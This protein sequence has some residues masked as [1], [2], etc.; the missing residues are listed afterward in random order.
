[1]RSEFTFRL[2]LLLAASLPVFCF[3]QPFHD[4]E[5]HSPYPVASA[6]YGACSAANGD[7]IL[8]G[9]TYDEDSSDVLVERISGAGTWIW[10]TR[11]RGSQ[12]AGTDTAVSVYETPQG[13]LR[14]VATAYE[15]ASTSFAA[16][17]ELSASGQVL[18]SW[19]LGG[20]GSGMIAYHGIQTYD[21]NTVI[22]GFRR[23]LGGPSDPDGFLLKKRADGDTLWTRRFELRSGGL[24]SVLEIPGGGFY[25]AGYAYAP[26]RTNF[27]MWLI[28][29][30]TLGV[31]QWR[32]NY[33]SN[34]HDYC[35]DVSLTAGGDVYLAGSQRAGTTYAG[36]LHK[37]TASGTPIW[38]F[39]L[40]EP[41]E[42]RQFYGIAGRPAG[43][44]IAVG[45]TVLTGGSRKLWCV[46]RANSGASEG[47]WSWGESETSGLNGI[48]QT[49]Q[50]GWI[51]VG[52]KVENDLTRGYAMLL[53]APTG[54]RGQLVSR[55]THEPL[56]NVSVA[57]TA[58]ASATV[59]SIAGYYSL[60][61]DPGVYDI[62]TY[63]SCVETDTTFGITV[64]EDSSSVRNIEVG[65]PAYDRRLTSLNLVGQNDV[66]TTTQIYFRNTGTGELYFGIGVENSHPASNWIWPLPSYGVIYPGDSVA[67]VIHLAP[68]TTNNG[69]WEFSSTLVVHMNT[70]P[71][72]VDRIPVLVTVLD[73]DERALLPRELTMSA[74][75]PN[76]FNAATTIRYELGQ[77]A[78]VRLSIF[79]LTG[80]EVRALVAMVQEPGTHAVRFE[81][82]ELASGVYF[83]RLVA[84]DFSA[85]TKLLLLK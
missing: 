6:F 3:A 80:R 82:A 74:L 65:V 45:T 27:D 46:T 21:G 49:N 62:V 42:S 9:T 19:R 24:R 71:D 34:G 76:P 81:G 4:W 63:G 55:E 59:S 60:E 10:T 32:L 5:Y 12:W 83:V 43:G 28:R 30:D 73:A 44:C 53:P 64:P 1:M 85:A 38:N 56:R 58:G 69:A 8:V 35:F 67:V 79:D 29:T 68:D 47:D 84:G 33:G 7:Y 72:S 77:R 22:A 48:F 70:C 51:I 66:V 2:I 41:G 37:V 31:E 52:A 16:V 57:T 40:A 54:V 39:V 20:F 50:G 15:S 18:S 26:E 14:V 11:V 61:L 78:A 75:Y 25:A 17:I 23:G 13:S 36:Y